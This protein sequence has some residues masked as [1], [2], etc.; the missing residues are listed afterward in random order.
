[1]KKI[2]VSILMLNSCLGFAGT[3]GT[4]CTPENVT[5]PC[6]STYWDFGVQALYL[7]PTFSGNQYWY[8]FSGYHTDGVSNYFNQKNNDWDWAFRLEGSY[9]F[10]TGS[11]VTI[12]WAHLDQKYTTP[13]ITYT[14][15]V[16]G[17]TLG[18]AYDNTNQ[19]WDA[20]NAELGQHANF[21]VFKD[22][23]FHAGIQYTY[24]NRN[25]YA[26]LSVFDPVN[27]TTVYT[28]NRT[29]Q[30]FSGAGPRVGMDLAYNVTNS[31]AVYGKFA[32]ALLIGDNKVDDISGPQQ[33]PFSYSSTME[34]IPEFEGKLG[35]TYT[36]NMSQGQLIADAGY[37][38][39]NYFSVLELPG[40]VAAAS[41]LAFQGP[42]AGLKW[43]GNLA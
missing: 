18:F 12:N 1:M 31:F 16:S 26:P 32:G 24:L 20:V 23:R 4:V 10:G 2:A 9:H 17:N 14:S 27:V 36:H 7:K 3:M 30:Q 29:T 40:N 15:L 25:D 8:N 33:G 34:V 19:R 41:N 13:G 5:V 39:V 6:A 21:G 28:A 42:Y 38:V 43:I 37:M 11:D 35:L 22:I